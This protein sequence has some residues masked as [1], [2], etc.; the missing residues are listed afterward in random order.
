MDCFDNSVELK[1]NVILRISP[2]NEA[3]ED[4]RQ[5]LIPRTKSFNSPSTPPYKY[6]S[7]AFTPPGETSENF[8][9]KFWGQKR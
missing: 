8:L 9:T 6:S 7:F 5:H 4:M 3:S 1:F 2:S